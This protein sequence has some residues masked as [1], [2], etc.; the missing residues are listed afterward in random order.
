MPPESQLRF[1]SPVAITNGPINGFAVG[2]NDYREAFAPVEGLINL[3][4]ADPGILKLLPLTVSP[5]GYSSN[6]VVSAGLKVAADGLVDARQ[7]DLTVNPNLARPFRSTLSLLDKSDGGVAQSTAT[8]PATASGF[9][10]FDATAPTAEQPF[11]G[12]LSGR[13]SP[14]GSTTDDANFYD[15]EDDYEASIL[16]MTRLSNLT[17]TRSDSY[18]VYV[19]VQ[20][21]RLGTTGP[22]GANPARLERQQRV[23]F[24]VDRAGV[25][26]FNPANNRPWQPADA[27]GQAALDALRVRPIPVE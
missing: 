13:I 7:P 10:P 1:L 9:A 27:D 18:T 24:T 19:V 17:T 23:A 12:D 26:P 5:T 3:N 20:A 6:S 2:D 4:T 16:D 15:A 22:G 14:S 25:L 21:W 11:R 8:P